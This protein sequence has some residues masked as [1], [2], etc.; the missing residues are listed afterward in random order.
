MVRSWHLKIP[1]LNENLTL[2]AMSNHK[3]Y[4]IFSSS[5]FLLNDFTHNKLCTNSLIMYKCISNIPLS[6]DLHLLKQYF[7]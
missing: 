5:V 3:F 7:I 1:L 6:T 2:Q 4:D